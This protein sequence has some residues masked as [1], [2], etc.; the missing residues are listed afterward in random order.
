MSG[1]VNIL[2]VVEALYKFSGGCFFLCVCIF[3]LAENV[4]L[5]FLCFRVQ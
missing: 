2:S 4:W 1:V 3:L 5:D